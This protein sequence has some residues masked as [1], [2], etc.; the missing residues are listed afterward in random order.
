MGTAEKDNK[1]H[2]FLR[3]MLKT[4]AK[5]SEAYHNNSADHLRVYTHLGTCTGMSPACSNIR[6][7]SCLASLRIHQ[8]LKFPKM[9]HNFV[10]KHLSTS[11]WDND[12]LLGFWGDNLEL[13]M[14]ETTH[15]KIGP[16]CARSAVSID[17]HSKRTFTPVRPHRVQAEIRAFIRSIETFI[18]IYNGNLHVEAYF[19]LKCQEISTEQPSVLFTMV[20]TD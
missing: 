1:F 12:A 17:H 8:C 3:A 2:T 5:T 11:Y 7:C 13:G 6:D 18:N 15:F 19:R 4:D 14:T 20:E 16:T 10:L 9:P